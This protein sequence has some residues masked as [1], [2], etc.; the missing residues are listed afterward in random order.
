[1]TLL[2]LG[3][4]LWALVHFVPSLAPRI[5]VAWTEALGAGGYRA[6]FSIIVV[7]ALGL[8]VLGWRSTTPEF[9]YALPLGIRPVAL[10]FLV[11]AFVLFGAAKHPTRIKQFIRHPQLTGLVV[12]AIAHLL[13]NGD[14]R[15][16]VLFGGLGIWAILEILF[17]NRREGAWVKPEVPSWG[18]ELRGLAISA[19]IFLVVVFIHP[20]IA[21]VP[22]R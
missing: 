10:L 7:A 14:S 1:M 12:W 4:A 19:V 16:V 6:S 17:I 8:M 13:L 3:I 9:L 20:Y 21:G 2:L 5:K 11:T 22:V 15:S 18:V